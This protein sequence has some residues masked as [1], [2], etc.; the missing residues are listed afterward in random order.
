M[1]AKVNFAITFAAQRRVLEA[2]SLRSRRGRDTQAD[3][4]FNACA[5]ET[6]QRTD[7]VEQCIRDAGICTY[8]RVWRFFTIT[9]KIETK[10][11]YYEMS[12]L[13]AVKITINMPPYDICEKVSVL[14]FRRNR[15][16]GCL[17]T[18]RPKE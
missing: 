16:Q 12:R 5:R 15:D 11:Y 18:N 14:C 6:L 9:N 13:S 2:T 10:G 7:M 1:D 8:E 17:S 3:K 4:K